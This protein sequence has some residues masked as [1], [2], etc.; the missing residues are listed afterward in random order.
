[1]FRLNYKSKISVNDL[2][3]ESM[4]FIKIRINFME[5]IYSENY[6]C[7]QQNMGYKR[8]IVSL[9]KKFKE[10]NEVMS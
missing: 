10:F 6:L 2:Q 7:E 4:F 9:I 1:M 5:L 3:R 8:I